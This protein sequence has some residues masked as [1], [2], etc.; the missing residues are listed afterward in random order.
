MFQ[1]NNLAAAAPPFDSGGGC[2]MVPCVKRVSLLTS[3]SALQHRLQP[4]CPSPINIS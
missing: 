3:G 2:R 4:S 1:K